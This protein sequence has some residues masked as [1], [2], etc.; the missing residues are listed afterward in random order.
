M[1]SE[2]N[3]LS[4][5]LRGRRA[6]PTSTIRNHLI[7]LISALTPDDFGAHEAVTRPEVLVPRLFQRLGIG[8]GEEHCAISRRRNTTS[9]LDIESELLFH[10]TRFQSA[11]TQNLEPLLRF[12]HWAPPGYVDLGGLHLVGQ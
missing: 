5:E 4:A 8:R 10:S 7:V 3:A 1:A 2:A 12:A 11:A 9:T 6:Q